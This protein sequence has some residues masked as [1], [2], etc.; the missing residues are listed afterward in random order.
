MSF[1]KQVGEVFNWKDK[2]LVVK[3]AERCEDCFFFDYM[4]CAEFIF[5]TGPCTKRKDGNNVKFIELK[6]DNDG[7]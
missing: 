4:D 5:T 6:K 3:K 2:T 1:E 7:E